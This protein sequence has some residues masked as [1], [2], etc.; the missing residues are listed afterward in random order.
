MRRSAYVVFMIG[1]VQALTA[2]ADG[3]ARAYAERFLRVDELA[4]FRPV[5]KV[6]SFSSYDRSGGNDD[7]F[8]GKNSFLRKE[9]EDA[10]VIAELK[11][12]GVLTRIW[13]PTATPD[14]IEFYFDGEETPRLRLP[15]DELFHGKTAPFV[16]PLVYEGAGGHVSYVPLE[17][18]KS[19]K[20][21][22]RAPRFMFY[23]INYA[24]YEPGTPARTFQV[25]DVIAAP[26]LAAA[27]TGNIVKG[28]HVLKPGGT[29]TVFEADRPGRITR[30]RLG[31]AA[32][33]A[34]RDRAIV[35]RAFW[36]GAE[37]PAVE[38]PAGDFFG[39]SFGVPSARGRLI[40]GTDDGWSYVNFPMPF[41]RAAR[42]EL[43]DERTDGPPIVVQSEVTVEDR[44]LQEDEGLFHAIWRRENPTTVGK[45]FTFVDVTG[46]GQMVGVTLQAQGLEAGQTS[47][48]EG[49]D[50]ATIDGETT[51]RG[52]GSEDFFNGGWYDGHGRWYARASFADSGCLEYT[53]P[54][55]RTGA[56]RT[57]VGDAYSFRKGLVATIEHAPTG[58]KV[59]TD[60]TG[61]TFFYLDR[62]EGIGPRLAGPSARVVR[63][64]DSVVLV[65]GWQAPIDGFSLDRATLAKAEE[66]ING[67]SVRYLSIRPSGQPSFQ[68]QFLAFTADVPT[69]GVYTVA[70]EAL[71]GPEAGR[72]QLLVQDQPIGA[73]VDLRADARGVSGI[74]PLGE[75]ELRAGPNPISF[76][77]E[78]GDPKTPARGVDLIR[79]HLKRKV[80]G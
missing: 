48:F 77:I 33:L 24:L 50:E 46:R 61:V 12:P 23:Q 41:R 76:S 10:L 54:L 13:T 30:L 29:V 75:V 38:V 43:V 73:V 64:P 26:A 70:V 40:G 19:I 1:S 9:G 44:P 53:K 51:I 66:N 69:G 31:P 5:T 17:F 21:V 80:G 57:F 74:R 25:G 35:L 42:V 6:G 58:N 37:A 71:T 45:P 14:P 3:P 18:E 59:L 52:T 49:D 28:E 47:F 62:S 60:Y 15:F 20:V 63:E 11:G 34:G 22:V 72:V 27:E 32:A 4:R 16:G 55:G 36:D 65:P 67:K 78:S 7:G 39:A 68:G 79:V 8:S 2:A 56:Y